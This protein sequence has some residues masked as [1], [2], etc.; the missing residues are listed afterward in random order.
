M[1][2][3]NISAIG[4]S[5]NVKPIPIIH[6]IPPSSA[7]VV[8]VT[9]D[10]KN[11]GEIDV[12]DFI[13]NADFNVGVT[14]TI[15]NFTINILDPD[16]TFLNMINNFDDVYIYGDYSD[17]ATTLRHRFKVESKGFLD[18]KTS[19]SGRGIGMIL[20]EKS[21]IYQSL[22]DSVLSYKN[23]S[24]VI[25]EILQQ[26]FTEITDFSQIESD[27][28]QIQKS[29]FEIPFMDIIEELC[30][31]SHY[32]YLDK[33]LIPHYFT[34]GSI[35]N[36]TEIITHD[37]LITMNDNSNNSE[38]IYTRVRVYGQTEDGIPV[39]HTKVIGTTNTGGINKDYIIN[40]R[41]VE[42][43]DQ[44][45]LL[46]ESVALDLTNSKD[47]Q[48]LVTLMLPSLVQGES[49]YVSIPEENISP[50][51]YNVKE[52]SF[53]IDN[54]G[55]YPLRTNFVVEKKRQNT[56]EVIKT[57][58]QTQ[59]ESTKNEN[60]YDKDFSKIITFEE[61][62]GSHSNTEINENYLKV[63]PGQSQ[64]T[65]ESQIYT[66]DSN[67]SSIE[68]RWSGDNLV[69][70]YSVTSAQLWVSLNGGTSWI[71]YNYEN[72]TTLYSNKYLKIRVEFNSSDQ[73][74]KRI[75]VY[76]NY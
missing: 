18:F 32:F 13:V 57:I 56:P 63:S 19:L 29:Y 10:T 2:V 55:D 15:G 65:W 54:E 45:Q 8:K 9:I 16:K 39:I 62:I 46:A 53:Q 51:Y 42:N 21:I 23:K 37:N 50:G 68:L 31:E 47:I 48:D 76:F 1:P 7:A 35:Q 4:P 12:T 38:D 69:Q 67:V 25:I 33:D 49:V 64:G 22:T 75:G 36:T 41:S 6:N 24:D 14:S 27:T 58:I 5:G 26:N 73:R 52:F 66:L 30:G 72:I 59:N 43:T 74:V 28:T 60:P 17:E 34:K 3:K 61:D 70:D 11:D 44:A 40:N 20:S 71:I